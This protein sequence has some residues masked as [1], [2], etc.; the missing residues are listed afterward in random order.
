L[1]SAA[2]NQDV[3]G[4][5]PKEGRDGEGGEAQKENSIVQTHFCKL[6]FAG[7]E[8]HANTVYAI[9]RTLGN[10]NDGPLVK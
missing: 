8:P 9:Y 10:D 1:P 7:K 2:T 6:I 5:L 3:A 4:K